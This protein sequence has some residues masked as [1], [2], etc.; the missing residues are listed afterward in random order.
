MDYNILRSPLFP[1]QFPLYISPAGILS[2]LYCILDKGNATVT[3]FHGKLEPPLIQHL[4]RIAAKA[5]DLIKGLGPIPVHW[6]LLIFLKDNGHV[7][8][9]QF[10]QKIQLVVRIQA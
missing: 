1:E 2:E 4:W 7:E 6:S 8:S 5:A 10:H 9:V 3:L